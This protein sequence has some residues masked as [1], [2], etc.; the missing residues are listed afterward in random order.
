M[1]F[2]FNF[3]SRKG[4]EGISSGRIGAPKMELGDDASHLSGM[5]NSVEPGVNR[6]LSL[7][8]HS[9]S[10]LPSDSFW[11]SLTRTNRAS[12]KVE[13]AQTELS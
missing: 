13:N 10:H 8:E 6:S 2:F 1:H 12:G 11:S 4:G 9:V 7:P 3:Y 5:Q